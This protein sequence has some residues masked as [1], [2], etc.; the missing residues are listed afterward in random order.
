[1]EVSGQFHGPAAL[2]TG[3][4]PP[5]LMNDSQLPSNCRNDVYIKHTSYNGQ[6]PTQYSYNILIIVIKLQRT[7]SKPVNLPP[8][9]SDR[10]E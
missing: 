10:H 1:M 5:V 3:K 9:G 6:C 2:P 8:P 4:E 7:T